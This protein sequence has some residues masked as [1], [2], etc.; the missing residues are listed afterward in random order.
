MDNDTFQLDKLL[1]RIRAQS[2]SGIPA[3]RKAALLLIAID[4][5]VAEQA[6]HVDEST[7]QPP[8][9]YFGALITLLEQQ[10]GASATSNSSGNNM[11]EDGNDQDDSYQDREE[12]V[13]AIMHLLGIVFTKINTQILRL[14]F[15]VLSQ[16]LHSTI[17]SFSPS[18]AITRDA[19][20]CLESLL[21]AMDLAT[22]QQSTSAM[23][24]R[25]AVLKGLTTSI[26][27]LTLDERPKVR[28]RAQECVRKILGFPPPPAL[29]HPFMIVVVEYY[30][31][32][33]R[34]AAEA[35]ASAP[36]PVNKK[37][38]NSKSAPV[39]NENEAVVLDVLVFLKGLGSVLGGK[40]GGGDEKVRNAVGLL[41][42]S[43]LRVGEG[44]GGNIVLMQWVFQVLT[45]ICTA[46]T[47][48]TAPPNIS[49][50]TSHS[51][52]SKSLSTL[53]PYHNDASLAPLWLSLVETSFSCTSAVLQRDIANEDDAEGIEAKKY[54][55]TAYPELVAEF[56]KKDFSALIGAT[57]AKR[58]VVE[59]AVEAYVSVLQFGVADFMVESAIV[60]RAS[61]SGAKN[62]W[63]EV[64]GAILVVLKNAVEA[65]TFRENWG[66][67]LIL[68]ESAFERVGPTVP[69]MVDPLISTLV[70]IRDGANYADDYP[71]KAEL[72]TALEAGALAMGL[73]RFTMTAPLNI[74]DVA[75]TETR[76]PYLLSL[77]TRA[78]KR[79][80][81]QSASKFGPSNLNYFTES[82]LPLYN[83]L[84]QRGADLKKKGL[85]HPAKLFE[86]LATQ[87]FGLFPAIC[88]T[89]P[90]DLVEAYDTLFP[91]MLSLLQTQSED[92]EI[93]EDGGLSET[94]VRPLIYNGLQ[95]LV[96]GYSAIHASLQSSVTAAEEVE[97]EESAA[98]MQ[99]RD[100]LESAGQGLHRLSSSVNKFLSVLCTV[101]TTPPDWI[102]KTGENKGA[103]LQSMHDRGQAAL[104]GCIQAFMGI[105]EGKAVTGY[106]YQLVKNVLQ[107][108]NAASERESDMKAEEEEDVAAEVALAK[109]KV[110][111]MV[112]LLCVLVLFLPEVKALAEVEEGEEAAEIPA[113]SP[114]HVFYKLLSG[115]LRD[116][117][118][119][120]QKKTY[121]SLNLL[122]AVLPGTQAPYKD[123]M[124][125]L[126][127]PEVISRTTSGVK[128]ARMRLIQLVVEAT[129]ASKKS[130]NDEEVEDDE[131]ALLLEFVPVVLSEVMLTT[132]EASEKARTAA[133][134]CL[135]AM[136]RKM[137]EVGIRR[138]RDAEWE[139]TRRK[140]KGGDEEDMEEEKREVSFKEYMMMVVA[141]LAGSSTTMQSAAIACCGRLL[142]EFHDNTVDVMGEEL[143]K[144]IVSTILLF[145]ASPNREIVKAA[146]GFIKV[147]LVTLP[148][149]Y[150]ADELESIIT[151]I[152]TH[153]RPH[154]SAFKSKVKN[155]LERLIRKFSFEAVEGFIPETDF[156]LIRNIR[157]VRERQL[158]K[159]SEAKAA[160][161]AAAGDDG[162]D[163]SDEDNAASKLALKTK[164]SMQSRQKEF[165][166]ALHGSED[167]DGDSDD[168]DDDHYIPEQYRDA[169]QNKK[170]QHAG[171]KSMIREDDDVVDFLDSQVISR[172]T[173][174]KS[175]AASRQS[176]ANSKRKRAS[177]FNV[178][179]D[180]RIM[181]AESDDEATAKMK[182]LTTADEPEDYYKQ[183]ITG[184]G[185]YK[186]LPD[187]RIKFVNKRKRGDDDEEGAEAKHDRLG[188]GASNMGGRWGHKNLNKKKVGMDEA[189]KGK[190]LGAQYKSKRAKGDV[191]KANMPDP[192]AYI[193]LSGKIVGSK[194]KSTELSKDFKDVI[195]ASVS[196]REAGPSNRG[197]GAGG[198]GHRGVKKSNKKHK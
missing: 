176:D 78:M 34:S 190:M 31:E 128:R 68:I 92:L 151:S 125:K 21:L 49:L 118:A 153:S 152:L 180:G 157:K 79:S 73:E 145:M 109:L 65:V 96:E 192:Y 4:K 63:A 163:A 156:K 74:F 83:A 139:A 123:L 64:L 155:I 10:L 135:V 183:S 53:R 99:M 76:R 133:Y 8:L 144:E 58:V 110:Y 3:Q 195:K 48:K 146:L 44:A 9:A 130:D 77:F 131:E 69:N 6:D 98:L 20:S 137:L 114:L 36:A 154:K 30:C 57:G 191:K 66:A 11:D 196:R 56:W 158:K 85:A 187:G 93:T 170:S 82:I 120:L 24:G 75:E 197:G 113:D 71:F 14:K 193:P 182:N 90:K 61:S 160:S 45:S 185:A 173:S 143:C 117:D 102:L 148:Q 174:G 19:L 33:L 169:V 39:P 15:N 112:D 23:V 186:R 107:L 162:D 5:T 84:Q 184:E 62:V 164:K 86:T 2:S 54:S 142:F 12:I 88:S 136:G 89:T 18:S 80:P 87:A 59:K 7:P 172:V 32:V 122:M 41:C 1:Q 121:K 38:K 181:I 188:A 116:R 50:E 52:L 189:T 178:N 37:G 81:I 72:D 175:N 60:R 94:D 42:D 43:V 105:A 149:P 35:A 40:I 132:K 115:Q 141:G 194:K 147:I 97:M 124:A 198:G 108:Q 140:L 27:S 138:Q 47:P 106:F 134:E 16:T 129:T 103:V 28:K 46:Q 26:L 119:T 166:D 179:D 168:G 101:Y 165:E 55:A 150:L 126:I 95:A 70:S 67:V 25:P 104:E 171:A 127:D 91:Q 100:D 13:T 29:V 22:W 159:K 167:E 51:I 177:E 17:Q 161:S 111:S